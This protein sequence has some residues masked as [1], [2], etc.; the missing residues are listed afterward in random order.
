MTP[1]KKV[2]LTLV[3]KRPVT[4]LSYTYT[5]MHMLGADSS[6][7][8]LTAK[9]PNLH[10]TYSEYFTVRRGSGQFGDNGVAVSTFMTPCLFSPYLSK[11]L[12][13]FCELKTSAFAK[14]GHLSPVNLSR[15]LQTLTH[16][17]RGQYKIF[18]IL[19]VT[20]YSLQIS[21]VLLKA[22]QCGHLSLGR[23]GNQ[24]HESLWGSK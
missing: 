24:Q 22:F 10:L 9:G 21:L 5:Y 3:I 7:I 23:L 18:L 16:H 20:N 17:A 11:V 4:E 12:P 1:I 14:I 13:T 8:K 15:K 6:H 19:S 2:T